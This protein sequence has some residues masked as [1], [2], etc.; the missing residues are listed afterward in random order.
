MTMT[1]EDKEMAE[2]AKAAEAKAE[3]SEAP[4]VRVDELLDLLEAPADDSSDDFD[5]VGLPP[6]VLAMPLGTI[7]GDEL[8]LYLADLAPTKAEIDGAVE[9]A[10]DGAAIAT[11]E[12]AASCHRAPPAPPAAPPPSVTPSV[13]TSQQTRA[14]P[15]GRS[16][17]SQSTSAGPTGRFKAVE[18]WA[19]E[20]EPELKSDGRRARA[21]S[22]GSPFRSLPRDD[23]SP[24]EPEVSTVE[25]TYQPAWK[26]KNL[27]KELE[28]IS[29]IEAT[30]I[31]IRQGLQDLQ[32]E[33]DT[34]DVD[35]DAAAL[36]LE[37]RGGRSTK[38]AA[39]R[40]SSV[41]HEAMA[42]LAEL[43]AVKESG[44]SQVNEG[45]EAAQSDRPWHLEV[46]K[47]RKTLNAFNDAK[48]T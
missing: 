2:L 32:E 20:D 24:E 39:R 5:E 45:S 12:A 21:R 22:P 26:R 7:D 13:S 15:V 1:E 46:M 35:A 30:A 37:L 17:P 31:A 48:D 16:L 4:A 10:A 34:C 28:E 9:A 36:M 42:L 3:V 8:R 43:Q 6:A 38:T 44:R 19:A 18:A 33:K 25:E 29:A 47:M 11:P 14:A 27:E 40:S 41:D 23:V